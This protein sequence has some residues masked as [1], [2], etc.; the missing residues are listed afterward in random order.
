MKRP[1]G[2]LDVSKL[3]QSFDKTKDGKSILPNGKIDLER[4]GGKGSLDLREHP[5]IDLSNFAEPPL[6]PG[7][8]VESLEPDDTNPQSNRKPHCAFPQSEHL[9]KKTEQNFVLP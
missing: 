7:I 8:D 6:T 3:A 1:D 9:P 2:S 4:Y 5:E